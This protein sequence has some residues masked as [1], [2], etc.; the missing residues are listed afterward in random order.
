M[1]VKI[2]P[3]RFS[4]GFRGDLQLPTWLNFGNTANKLS[5]ATVRLAWPQIDYFLFYCRDPPPLSA[6]SW[7]CQMTR[8]YICV[9]FAWHG[10]FPSRRQRRLAHQPRTL[11][12]SKFS[13]GARFYSHRT[14]HWVQQRTFAEIREIDKPAFVMRPQSQSASRIVQCLPI[15]RQP[16]SI[17]LSKKTRAITSESQVVHF[18]R[19]DGFSK[20]IIASNMPAFA[21][22]RPGFICSAIAIGPLVSYQLDSLSCCTYKE[23]GSSLRRA[24]VFHGHQNP[25]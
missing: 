10:S 13:V 22:D 25:L 15:P 9:A 4:R 12:T 11:M 2:S 14:L 19:T 21:S 23:E 1:P 5:Q 17:F 24:G 6:P 16:L 8:K 3:K 18:G 20:R 7:P